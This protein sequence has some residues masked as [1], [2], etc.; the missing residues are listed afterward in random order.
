MPKTETL[1]A[2]V[3]LGLHILTF[4]LSALSGWSLVII[5]WLLRLETLVA[6]SLSVHTLIEDWQK[7]YDVEIFPLT[8]LIM[9]TVSFI[10]SWYPVPGAVIWIIFVL[11]SLIVGALAFFALTFEMRM[12]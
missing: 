6:I 11:H 10:C 7:G 2:L 4:G 3:P 1:L 8:F 9:G 12:F 5:V